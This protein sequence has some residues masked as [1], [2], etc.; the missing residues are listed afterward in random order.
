LAL[1]ELE[2][3]V[4]VLQVVMEPIP[5]STLLPLLLL[6]VQVVAALVAPEVQAVLGLMEMLMGVMVQQIQAMVVV[7]VVAPE[8][9]TGL[10]I[11][12]VIIAVLLFLAALVGVDVMLAV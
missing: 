12:P 5:H 3:V 9:L 4:A 8:A 6:A 2:V 10:A 7:V 11:G 1:V